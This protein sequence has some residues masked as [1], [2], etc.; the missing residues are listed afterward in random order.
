[1]ILL[2]SVIPNVLKESGIN[3]NSDIWGTKCIFKKAKNYL[4]TAPSGK[5]KST[6]IHILYGIRKD[7]E[8]KVMINDSSSDD[9]NPTKWSN[10]RQQYFSIVFQDLRLFPQLTAKENILLKAQLNNEYQWEEIEHMAEKLGVIGLLSQKA[11]ELS[12]GQKQRIAIIRAMCQPFEYLL[13]DEPFSHLDEENINIC[14]KLILKEAK[15]RKAGL[16]LV[17]L[18]NEYGIEFDAK[19][20]L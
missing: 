16:I 7:Y 19:K 4:V 8:G 3:D 6:L 15:K 20:I 9:F 13:L 2:Q 11:G 14:R 17:S 1:M 12:Y 5:G 10:L 18:G